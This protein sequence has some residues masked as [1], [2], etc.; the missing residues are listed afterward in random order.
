MHDRRFEPRFQMDEPAELH[1]TDPNGASQQCTGF[2]RDYSRSGV[3]IETERAVRV[4][5]KVQLRIRDQQ[6]SGS[7]KSCRRSAGGLILGLELDPG[8]EGALQAPQGTP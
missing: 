5:T 7:V 1:W 3:C 2:V 6:L 4:E 8:S